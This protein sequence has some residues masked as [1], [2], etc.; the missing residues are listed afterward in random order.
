MLITDLLISIYL[1]ARQCICIHL[2]SYRDKFNLLVWVSHCC[3]SSQEEKKITVLIQRHGRLYSR[4]RPRHTQFCNWAL[5][6][7][8][9]PYG[10]SNHDERFFHLVWIVQGPLPFVR[11][12]LFTVVCSVTWPLNESE[13]GGDLVMIE[14][15]LLLLCKFLLISMRTAS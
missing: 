10:F 11:I 13:A 2:D 6:K 4:C 9:I 12:D 3:H 14:T 1:V 8:N 5:G 15:L 7:K